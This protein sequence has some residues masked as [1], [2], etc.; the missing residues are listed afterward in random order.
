MRKS[1]PVR[2]ELMI[3]KAV[4]RRGKNGLMEIKNTLQGY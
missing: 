3:D 1:D 2:R 4:A